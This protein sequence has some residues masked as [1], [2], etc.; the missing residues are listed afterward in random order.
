MLY[1]G[2]DGLGFRSP[3]KTIRQLDVVNGRGAWISLL[4]GQGALIVRSIT[5]QL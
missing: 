2:A 5:S 3:P 4:S 1:L